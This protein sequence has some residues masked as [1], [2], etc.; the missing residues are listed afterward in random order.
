FRKVPAFR[1]F[2]DKYMDFYESTIAIFEQ[3]TPQ[4]LRAI[5]LRL[6]EINNLLAKHNDWPEQKLT[7]FLTSKINHSDELRGVMAVVMK[8]LGDPRPLLNKGEAFTVMYEDDKDFKPGIDSLK[9][10]WADKFFAGGPGILLDKFNVGTLGYK[11]PTE[12]ML[13]HM[14]FGVDLDKNENMFRDAK[15][16]RQF[17]GGMPSVFS[18]PKI[19]K[20][21]QVGNSSIPLLNALNNV[22]MTGDVFTKPYKFSGTEQ[23][24]WDL[25]KNPSNI[26]PKLIGEGKFDNWW[27]VNVKKAGYQSQWTQWEKEYLEIM[28]TL[29]KRLWRKDDIQEDTA[30]GISALWEKGKDLTMWDGPRKSNNDTVFNKS[31]VSNGIVEEL[32]QERK[33]Y[34]LI[35]GEI[36]K[37]AGI[38][39]EAGN[40][41]A[42]TLRKPVKVKAPDSLLRYL[43]AS[44]GLNMADYYNQEKGQTQF[45]NFLFQGELTRDF[46]AMEALLAEVKVVKSA[47]YRFKAD[48]FTVVSRVSNAQF[49]EVRARLETTIKSVEEKA[50]GLQLNDIQKKTLAVCLDGIRGVA[51]QLKSYGQIINAVSYR[52]ADGKGAK[53]PVCTG[54]AKS[55]SMTARLKS[56]ICEQKDY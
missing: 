21:F 36:L 55:A 12:L 44:P 26:D 37:S 52:D 39:H 46:Y 4:N 30:T 19:T 10:D 17:L 23:T 49:D 41:H 24:V 35:L 22:S 45:T 25:I 38:K 31:P 2:T 8:K 50:N 5:G 13:G 32:T 20:D 14:A 51:D 11:R 47:D 15:I 56:A 43:R 9:W 33:L 53:K 1:K 28:P 6:R 16:M 48:E 42:F 27:D 34:M 40:V 29:I 18:A 54:M 7:A 3:A